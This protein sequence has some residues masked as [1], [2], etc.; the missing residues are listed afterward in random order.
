MANCIADY[1][2]HTKLQ[3]LTMKLNT[4]L[5]DRSLGKRKLEE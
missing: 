5:L 2:T 1:G 3:R 4:I